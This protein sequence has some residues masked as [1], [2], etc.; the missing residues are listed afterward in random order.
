MYKPVEIRKRK[1]LVVLIFVIS[2]IVAPNA[3]ASARNSTLNTLRGNGMC[4]TQN[5]GQIIDMDGKP[6]PDI[7]FKGAGNG[8][9][10]YLLK[11]GI[12]YVQ[13]DWEKVM[14]EIDENV[15][16]QEKSGK[17]DKEAEQK[18][19]HEL[20]LKAIV[21]FHRIDMGFE[22]GNLNP[23]IQTGEQ[24]EGYS[25]YFYAHCPK[26]VTNVNSYNE[27]IIKNIYDNIDVKYYGG[28]ESGVKYDIVINPGADPSQIRLK[29]SGADELKIKNA[30]LI[31][32]TSLGE[33]DEYMPRVYQNINGK[34]V[35]V[36]A[37]YVLHGTT[38][39]FEFGTHNPSY[40]LVIDPWVT[41]FGGSA[42]GGLDRGY[43]TTVGNDGYPLFTGITTSVNFPASVG[44][45]QT[46]FGAGSAGTGDAFIVKMNAITG[47]RVFATYFG[48]TDADYSY[49]IATDSGNNI[50]VT[51]LSVSPNLPTHNPGGGAYFQG[52][53]TG[54]GNMYNAF[55]AKFIPTG[56][57]LIWSTYYSDL[58]GHDIITDALGN[59]I[60]CGQAYSGWTQS[61]GRVI[62]FNS[63]YTL[64]WASTLIGN[65]ANSVAIDSGNNIFV[66]GTGGVIP[67][68]LAHQSVAGGAGDAFL[69]KYN[70]AGTIVWATYYGGTQVEQGYS[71]ATDGFDNAIM[72]G[73]TENSLNNISS[74][75]AQQTVPGGGWD[76][77][78]VKFNN[79]GIR[80]WGTYLGGSADE[81]GGIGG[82][83]I[84]K[85]NN[86]YVYGEWEDQGAG[87]YPINSCAYQPVFGGGPGGG[88]EDQYIAKYTPSGK[89]TCITY[90]GGSGHDDLEIGVGGAIAIQDNYIYV[91]GFTSGNYPV[92]PGAFQTVVGGG[93]DAF[94]DQLCINI[95]EGK[96]LALNFSA[97]A[98]SVCAG[99]PVTYIPSV[100]NSCDTSGY[101]FQWTFTGAS[102]VASGSVKPVITYPAPGTFPV[103]LVVTTP[104]KKDSLTKLSYI[105]VTGCACTMSATTA[106][107]S[108][109]SCAGGNN[110][111]A[112]VTISNGSGGVY[113]YSWSNGAN[114][115]TNTLTSQVSNLTV[116]TY[117]VTVTDGSCVSIA[118][119]NITQS[120]NIISITSTNP[121]CSG[122]NTGSATATVSAGSGGSYTYDWSNGSS[123]ITGS[124]TNSIANLAPGTYTVTIKQGS[125]TSTSTATVIQ[126]PAMSVGF[127]SQ[128]SCLTNKG[129]ANAF[130]ANGTPSYI[131]Q[132]NTGQVSPT[133]T[134]LNT[135]TYSIILTD[136]SGCTATG[137]IT[138]TNPPPIIITPSIGMAISCTSS[139][140]IQT[141]ITGGAIGPYTWTW[142]NGQSGAG[143]GGPSIQTPTSGS[144]SITVTDGNSCT[145]S[146]SINMTGSS[147]VSGAFVAPPNAC[148]G[149]SISFTNA[150][151][152]P[153]TGITYTWTIGAPVNVSGTTTN[154]SY[155]FL[156]AGTYSISH[157]VSNGTC[158]STIN[159]NITVINCNSP[160]VT[161]T[162]SSICS[163]SCAT[164]TSGGT[165]GVS[166][167]TFLWS[168]GS[169]SQNIS[170][171]PV[172]TT[173]YTV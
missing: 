54:V 16:E 113:T 127:S 2:Q 123:T 139:G 15:E 84:D 83:A 161:A 78:V 141:T 107:V 81:Y 35:N 91:T 68:L 111:T 27:I 125:C 20:S 57:G 109:V 56:A 9:D 24:V 65:V 39:N 43:A 131:Y 22:G 69:I 126:P 85:T 166:P 30:G 13:S 36:I 119:V 50:L 140:L 101:K 76:C 92:T 158:S 152:S 154:Y 6:R 87:N 37:R 171:C 40:P 99:A 142:S 79:S 104:C 153:G 122:V 102:P 18:L 144:Y 34:I 33:F 133:I 80:Q 61:G 162:G 31:I 88:N 58:E 120:Q 73:K 3:I 94:F 14:T 45:F 10:V 4:F 96:V 93:D 143:Y 44:A 70:P 157:T 170:P 134:G 156:S 29:Y 23:E 32:K 72:V 60:V 151:T 132:W 165:G 149:S 52:M 121:V 114:S 108:N 130:P 146:A 63:N 19:R 5:K 112:K 150:G 117:T 49:S 47:G 41:Y 64:Q 42:G 163:G 138:I 28:K 12:S 1:F 90:L 74:P 103:K 167:Y 8:A 95:C 21:K 26:G 46:V 82:V 129:V 145:A 53:P 148:I 71:V 118:T 48:G 115:I 11:T 89:Q 105:T 38:L 106:V 155:T 169:T 98:T 136:A 100:N 62:K 172:S 164:V 66:A 124:P 51:G 59:I 55:I 173:T 168:N 128:W 116:N 110:G 86:I 159:R 135:G 17:V 160:T 147:P 77:F 7:L 25:N 67:V 137:N 75:G 97:N